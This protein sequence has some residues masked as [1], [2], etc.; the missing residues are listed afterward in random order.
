MGYAAQGSI[1]QRSRAL[2]VRPLFSTLNDLHSWE[3]PWARWQN[4]TAA[5]L[6][7]E[8]CVACWL[9]VDRW[10]EP[11]RKSPTRGLLIGLVFIYNHTWL[12]CQ[13]LFFLSARMYYYFRRMEYSTS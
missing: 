7:Y 4:G 9:K 13:L 5:R 3:E 6:G 1:I 2:V 11:L 8:R 12:P 10:V